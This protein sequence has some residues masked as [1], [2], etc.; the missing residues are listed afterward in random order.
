M[1]K[2]HVRLPGHHEMNKLMSHGHRIRRSGT[3][4]AQKIHPIK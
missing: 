3:V 1:K 4:K 2:K